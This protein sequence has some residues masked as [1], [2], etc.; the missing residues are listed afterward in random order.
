VTLPNSLMHLLRSCDEYPCRA[1]PLLR[2]LVTLSAVFV[3][4]SCGKDAP[5]GTANKKAGAPGA[6]QAI[7]V[8]VKEVQPQRV[9]ITLE[10]VGQA[11]GSREVEVR[12]R[13]SGILEKRLFVEGAPV[14]AGAV[15]FVIER[16]PYEIAVAQARAALA[17]ERARQELALR[18][19]ERLKMLIQSRAISLR[20]YDEAQSSVKQVAAAIEAA[21]AKLDEA[22]LNL[23][24]TTVRAAISGITGRALRSEGSLVTANTD[25]S[26][27]TTLTQVDPVWVRFSLA[28][29]DFERIRGSEKRAQVSLASQNGNAAAKN[30][31]LNFAGST[32]DPK[33][34][35]VQLRAEFAN[36]GHRWLPGQFVKV[37][38]RAGEQDAFLVPQQAVMQTEQT[39]AVWVVTAD[40]T[41]SMRPV[42]TAGWHG[43]DWV[44]TDGLKPGEAVVID[45][46][47]KMRPGVGVRPQTGAAPQA[48]PAPPPV[49]KKT[50]SAPVR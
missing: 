15:L 33:L 46:L 29:P 13:V 20:E 34:G 39:R 25:A 43:T 41:A 36:P 31:K 23:S 1:R 6:P 16:A 45:N 19:A 21:Q 48:E 47:M 22:Q 18:E 8:T 35:T 28:G 24:W 32:V 30:G 14:K 12:G 50:A 40:G 7:P 5:D 38:I 3:L 37:E 27:L 44:V 11:E 17:Q 2:A 42:Q 10:A 49:E 9:P 4:V 26:L